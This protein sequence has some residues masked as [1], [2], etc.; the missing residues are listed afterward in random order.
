VPDIGQN[1]NIPVIEILVKPGEFVE[2]DQSIATLE[3]DKATID[4]P[5]S[6]RGTIKEIMLKLGDLVSEGTVFLL[7]DTVSPGEIEHMP[8]YAI[9]SVQERCDQENSK[10][11]ALA[12][13]PI[14]KIIPISPV[15]N[16]LLGKYAS[17]LAHKHARVFGVDINSVNSTGQ[18]GRISQQDVQSFIKSTLADMPNKNEGRLNLL[19]WP[20]IDFSKF[21]EVSRK[22][23]TRIQ[24]ISSENLS[25]NWIMIPA[26]TYH[27]DAD[28][29]EL[30]EFRKTIN[31]EANDQLHKITI[32]AFLIKTS[33]AALKKYPELNSSLDGEDLVLKQ[34]VHIGFAVDTPNGLM[35]PVIHNADQKGVY[36][37]ANEASN[38]ADLARQSKLR[39]DQIQGGSF[40]ISSL[41][42]IGGTYSA[43]I[44]NAPEVAILAVNQSAI[45]PIWNGSEFSPRLICPLSLTADHRVIDGALATRFNVYIAQLLCDFRKVI[46]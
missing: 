27:E 9:N 8:C 1:Q 33:A 24:K 38:L 2:I 15:N 44:I 42:G 13:L 14:A 20:Q 10:A 28:I 21:G 11:A 5:S 32:L 43:P 6:H 18:R 7:L 26:V 22:P 34:Y 12:S 46:L 45:K 23:L 19:S 17:P 37:I 39:T 35:V 3:S 16:Q 31:Q 4:M 36:E 41:G 25:R 30:E 29:T 40:T